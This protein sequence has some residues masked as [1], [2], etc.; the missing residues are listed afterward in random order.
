[1]LRRLWG[2]GSLS[3]AL[4]GSHCPAEAPSLPPSGREG[5][6]S[7]LLFSVCLH[8]RDVRTQPWELERGSAQRGELVE[9]TGELACDLQCPC[10]NVKCGGMHV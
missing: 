8:L 2:S 3:Q 1:M 9:R 4:T 7:P 10:E 6:S 5:C